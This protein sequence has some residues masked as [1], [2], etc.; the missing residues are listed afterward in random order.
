MS[1]LT[2]SDGSNF[3]ASA[4]QRAPDQRSPR[5][6]RADIAGRDPWTEAPRHARLRLQFRWLVAV[7]LANLSV[8][9]IDQQNLGDSFPAAASLRLFVVTPLVLIGLGVNVWSTNR[10]LQSAASAVATV[11]LV[12]ITSL[13]GQWAQEPIASRYMMAAQF[14]IFTAAVFAALPWR[15]TQ[16]MTA[17]AIAAYAPIVTGAMQVPRPLVNLDL[18]GFSILMAILALSIRRQE[19]V[20]MNEILAMRRIDAARTAELRKANAR[21]SQLSSTDALTGVFNRRYLDLF[22]ESWSTSLVPSLGSG[23]LMIDVD[24]FKLFND[25]GGHADGDRCLQRVAA[26]IQSALR[27]PDDIVV[28][29]GG[30]EFVVILPA[31]DQSE[32]LAVAERL[33]AA[34]GDLHIPHPGLGTGAVV[35]VSIG[36]CVATPG[37][38]ITDTIERADKLMYAAKKGG[39]N[40]V[41]A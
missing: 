35:T 4:D 21:L 41:S 25:L 5:G 1:L 23:V 24:H 19:E 12:V 28:R 37:E 29:Y 17:V 20:R 33:R 38:N 11:S 34:V 9:A 22:A 13:I 31:A 18:V 8:L 6:D 30:E 14:A 3:M 7:A 39:R 32:A 15:A 26:A 16:I 10:H 36:A 2:C 27:S 40:R